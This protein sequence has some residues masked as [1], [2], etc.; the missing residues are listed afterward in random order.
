MPLATL[1][2]PPLLLDMMNVQTGRLIW[3]VYRHTAHILRYLCQQYCGQ[4]SHIL[5][6]MF[7]VDKG[8]DPT[9]FATDYVAND[10]HE[11]IIVTHVYPLKYIWSMLYGREHESHKRNRF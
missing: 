10:F 6:V 3:F 2:S 8:D 9:L 11:T 5:S 1:T 7:V 4:D